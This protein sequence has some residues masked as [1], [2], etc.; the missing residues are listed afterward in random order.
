MALVILLSEIFSKWLGGLQVERILMRS[1]HWLLSLLIVGSCC[2]STAQVDP[3]EAQDGPSRRVSKDE[4]KKKF[5]PTPVIG[6]S[7]K[8]WLDGYKAHQALEAS[9]PFAGL[10]WRSVGP[11]KQSGR[12]NVIAAPSGDPGKVYVG[13]ATGGLWR[14]D[15]D[16]AT[17]TSLFDNQSAFSIGAIALSADGKTIWVGSGEENSQRTSY[18]GTGVFRSQDSGKTWQWMGLPE[19][20]HIGKI[21]IDPKNPN[22]V[23]VAALGHLYS[24]NPERGVFK[25]VD[26]GKTWSQVL[27]V[28]EYTGAVDMAMDPRNPSVLY[29]SMWQ[30]DRR[31]WDFL[32]SGPGSALYRSA[33]AGKS[34]KKVTA[35]PSGYAAGRIGLSLC[36][37]HPDT[38]YAFV[39]NQAEDEDWADHDE[40]VPSGRLTPRRFLHLSEETIQQVDKQKLTNFLHT[41]DKDMNVDDVLKQIKDKKLTFAQ[42]SDKLK[43]KSPNA[44]GGQTGAELY[45]TDDGGKTWHRT[46]RGQFGPFGGY[47]WGKVW[48]NP[49]D[50]NDVYVTALPLVRSKDGGKTW[51]SVFTR[52]HVDFH[53]VWNDP[54]DPRKVWVGNDG[55]LY[56]SYDGGSTIRHLN[57]LAVGQTTTLAVDNKTPY[58]IYTGLQDN[59][60]MKGPSSYRPGISDI[61]QWKDIFG[62]DGSAIAVDPRGDG[63]TVY[64]AYQFGE[65]SAINQLTGSSWN[66][67]ATPPKGDPAARYNWISP[68]VISSHDP[69]IIYLG[70]QRLYRSFDMGRHYKPIS[71]DLTKN[72]PEGNVPFSTIK[73]ISESPLR[74]GL[75]YVGCDDGNVQMTPDGGF[76]WISVPT[77]APDKWVSRVVASK[78]DEKTVYLSQS[79]YREDDF[80]PYLWKSTD[81]GKTWK[82]IVGNL[83]KETINVV[84]EDPNRN[85]VLYVGTD[86]GVYISFDGGTNWDIIKGNLPNTPVHDLV[87]QPSANDLVI[88]THARSVWIMPLSKVLS[89]TPEL[90]KTDLK[91]ETIDNES[92]PSSWGFDRKE[93]W[94]TSDPRA[95]K[96]TF[97]FW[98]KEPGKGSI[99]IVDKAGKVVKEKAVEA[100]RGFNSAVLELELTPQKRIIQRKVTVKT[101]A[102][103]LNDPYGSERA[104]YVP[105]GEYKLVLTIGTHSVD[106]AWKITK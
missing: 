16:G 47:Y 43:Q 89:I 83:P 57:N 3:D 56:L 46:D 4:Q 45:R 15:D 13:F 105:I 100:V 49:S 30:R 18:A 75:I 11:E 26:G 42:L 106:Q 90:R 101:G 85:D 6:M 48:V 92:D 66:A 103:A 71:P 12:V 59:G 58:N 8:E 50:P 91:L 96:L 76:Q 27:K 95:P 2:I 33:D 23:Y 63:D 24:Q 69:D 62:G 88:A 32:E 65:H 70:A 81:Y 99:K 14:T 72:H 64:V 60:T 36:L 44:F 79:G 7:A 97:N 77:P 94:D 55:G 87:V 25:T 68:I 93:R 9:S 31:A 102:D 86:M 29:A 52:A 40:A 22:V 34:W 10:N 5:H 37:S 35:V 41:Y 73:D 39:D 54:R 51:T 38:V 1:Y 98:T 80:S 67:R 19:S 74:F 20:H 78:W 84:R 17:W 28:D 53:A 61:E 104:A 21:L 82:S